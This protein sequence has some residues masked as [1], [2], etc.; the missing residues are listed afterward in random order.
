MQSQKENRGPFTGNTRLIFKKVDKSTGQI[1]D[2]FVA[3]LPKTSG[4]NS[5]MQPK[6]KELTSANMETPLNPKQQI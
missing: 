6:P 4:T 2:S 5:S 3:T 1:L